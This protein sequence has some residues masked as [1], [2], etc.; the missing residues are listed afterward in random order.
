MR[1]GTILDGARGAPAAAWHRVAISAVGLYPR[2]PRRSGMKGLVV[3][4]TRTGKTRRLAEAF[5]SACGGELEELYEV[6]IH[7]EGIGGWLRAG[8]DGM[9]QRTVAIE[10]TTRRAADYEVVFVGSPVWGGNLCPAVRTYLKE[11]GA[12]VKRAALFCTMNGEDDGG[13]FASMRSL[14]PS[15][16]VVGELAVRGRDT[17]DAEALRSRVGDWI[18]AVRRAA[19]A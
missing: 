2:R 3:F 1:S 19:G 4:F 11:A 13:T 18:D 16:E 6:G 9:R 17:A 8:R 10:P 12:G 7:R 5:A 15:A 14:M